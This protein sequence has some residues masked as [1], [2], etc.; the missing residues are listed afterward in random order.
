MPGRKLLPAYGFALSV[1]FVWIIRRGMNM[2]K[3]VTF[4][5]LLRLRDGSSEKDLNCL[6]L[7]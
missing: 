4:D 5:S 2:V 6:L 1:G 7:L 3:E